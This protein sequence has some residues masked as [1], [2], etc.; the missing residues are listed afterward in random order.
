MLLGR[1][2]RA[3]LTLFVVSP[4]AREGGRRSASSLCMASG[5]MASQPGW[6]TLIDESIKKNDVAHKNFGAAPRALVPAAPRAPVLLIPQSI[7][8]PRSL[9]ADELPFASHAT[10]AHANYGAPT[11]PGW[12]Q[13]RD[14]QLTDACP[15][16]SATGDG[17]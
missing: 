4:L 1:T 13:V 17:N 5:S 12:G 10:T 14:A 6:V 11:A 8:M 9:A 16:A 7:A 3:L 15:L 2:P